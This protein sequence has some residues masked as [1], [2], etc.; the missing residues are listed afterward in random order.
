MT[1]YTMKIFIPI[2]KLSSIKGGILL[3]YTDEL[4]KPSNSVVREE[5]KADLSM[6]KTMLDSKIF[7]WRSNNDGPI[8]RMEENLFTFLNEHSQVLSSEKH[9]RKKPQALKKI[10]E[11]IKW[12]ELSVRK[13]ARKRK[14]GAERRRFGFDPLRCRKIHI[15]QLWHNLL[16]RCF[17]YYY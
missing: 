6:D 16:L 12:F 14:V 1:F 5:M 15:P 7:P 8:I 3:N 4:I 2:I 13:T 9:Q 11:R 17:Y 10:D